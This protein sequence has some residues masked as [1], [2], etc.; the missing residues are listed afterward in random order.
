MQI[1]KPIYENGEFKG[2]IIAAEDM[3][4]LYHIRRKF[5]ESEKRYKGIFDTAPSII[6]SLDND[7]KI[8]DCNR[9]VSTLGYKP[10]D[11]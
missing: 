6:L 10:N 8:Q 3:T 5:E 2:A 9:M 7:L 1:C 4:K 11:R